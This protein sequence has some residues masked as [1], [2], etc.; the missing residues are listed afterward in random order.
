MEMAD[1]EKRLC[2]IVNNLMFKYRSDSD[3]QVSKRQEI[4]IRYVRMMCRKSTLFDAVSSSDEMP[5]YNPDSASNSRRKAVEDDRQLSFPSLLDYIVPDDTYSRVALYVGKRVS[6]V[7]DHEWPGPTILDYFAATG[8]YD[9]SGNPF[10]YIAGFM[11]K[12]SGIE[13]LAFNPFSGLRI[14]PAEA[15]SFKAR[16]E[17][18]ERFEE[19]AGIARV[20]AY[21][22]ALCDGE[23]YDAMSLDPHRPD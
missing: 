21:W 5:G 6:V 14:Y 12:G 16:E 11:K 23:F 3:N 18:K 13:V 1:E 22:T 15:F 4:L 19:Q 10:V 20:N 9:K 8:S 17:Q 2:R 7:T